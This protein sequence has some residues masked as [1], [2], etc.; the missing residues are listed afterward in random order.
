MGESS[1]TNRMWL[2]CFHGRVLVIVA[3]TGSWQPEA[4]I[5]LLQR[6]SEA[7]VRVG[8][9]TVGAIG[10]GLLAL[11]AVE[12]EDGE[13]EAERLVSKML[14][15]RIFADS[16][17]RMN[18]SLS[19]IN[20]GLLLVPQFTLLANTARGNRPSFSGAADPVRGAALFDLL[21]GLAAS[22]HGAVAS[23]RF[24]AHM[25]VRLI[26]DGPVTMSLRVPP[27]A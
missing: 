13:R 26:N 5:A 16:R 2:S 15:L 19:D 14:A 9:E 6:V 8:Q 4:M 17:N 25:A 11:V 3:P 21:V 27:L 23:G 7:D 24:G 10:P 12:P 20:G 22:R 18:R 1:E